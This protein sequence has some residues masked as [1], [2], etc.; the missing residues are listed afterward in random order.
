MNVWLFKLLATPA[1]IG[2]ATLA[3][4]RWGPVVNGLLVGLPL[5]TG[6]V[7]LILAYQ[8]GP[9][10]AAK[11]AAGNLAGQ[12]SMVLTSAGLRRL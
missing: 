7:S 11:A 10:F 6:P 3:G 9:A 12:V 5:T 8:Y 2:L 4:R 1:F